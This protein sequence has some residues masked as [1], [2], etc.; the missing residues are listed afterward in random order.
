MAEN[1]PLGQK[2]SGTLFLVVGPSGVGKDSLIDGARVA[3][4]GEV[5]F[6]F[7]QRTITR[8]ADAGGEDHRTITSD[9]FAAE[10]AAGKY[11]LSWQAH[12]LDYGIPVSIADDLSQGRSVI[13]NVSRGVLDAARQK[14][15]RVR[16]LSIRASEQTLAARLADRG[17]ESAEDIEQRIRRAAAYDVIGSDVIEIFN[18]GSLKDAIERVTAV[19]RDPG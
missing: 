13:V 7:P 19:L 18:D 14:F 3:L 8:A 6:V 17:R 12:G 5:G 4:A 10:A 16:V 2:P 1:D 11:A 15:G 9:R